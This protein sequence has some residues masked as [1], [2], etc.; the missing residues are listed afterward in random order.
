MKNIVLIPCWQRPEFL[1]ICLEQIVKADGAE[2]YTYVFLVDRGFNPENITV[3]NKFPFEKGVQLRKETVPGIGRQSMNLLE[4]YRF[5]ASQDC[6]LVFMIEE[7]I[8]IAND[9]FTWHEA[10]QKKESNFCSI[11]TENNNTKHESTGNLSEYYIGSER[12]Y[13]SLGVCFNREVLNKYVVPHANY[14]F[15]K[16]PRAYVSQKF[17]T[18]VMGTQYCEQDGLIRRIRETECNLPVIFP[19]VP[20]AYHAGFYGYNRPSKKVP[21]GSLA[22]RIAQL[23]EIIFSPEKMLANSI[24]PGYYED[25]KPINLINDKWLN[26]V[27]HEQSI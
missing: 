8:M 7:D 24:T 22:S 17:P 26:Q 27:R 15:Y 5:A 23:K 11:A 1:S 10:V 18:S 14:A 16:N 25:S 13:Q 3:I 2:K 21:K 9:F 20:R 12:D 6:N 19:D 4:G